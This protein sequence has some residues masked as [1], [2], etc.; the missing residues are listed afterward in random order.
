MSF[1][2]SLSSGTLMAGKIVYDQF[3][4]GNRTGLEPVL[5][6][7]A[8]PARAKQRVAEIG[9]GAGAGLLCLSQRLP[10]LDL[11]GI[12]ADA[13]SIEL[14][15]HNLAA[16]KRENVTLLQATFPYDLPGTLPFCRFDHCFANPPWHPTEGTPSPHAQRDLAR[17]ALT[18]TLESWIK[19]CTRLLRHKGSLTLI[20]PASLMSR[21]CTAL[22]EHR[23]GDVTLFPLWP[24]TGREA[25]LMLIQGRYGVK[26]PSRILPGLTLHTPEGGFTPESSRILKEGEALRLSLQQVQA[27]TRANPG[28]S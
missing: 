8:V 26:G 12:E 3:L 19:G 15:R 11:W 28:N 17:R 20:L 7:A 10:E 5:I 4:S 9:C 16:N 13:P 1:M 24:K 6:A 25:R 21:A 18:D 27:A 22:T 23:F 2:S 14:A